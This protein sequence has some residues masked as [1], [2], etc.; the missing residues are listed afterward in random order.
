MSYIRV[1]AP[2]RELFA[3]AALRYPRLCERTATCVSIPPLLDVCV[4]VRAGES[5]TGL[6]GT[7]VLSS[8]LEDTCCPPLESTLKSGISGS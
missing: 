3:F 7:K 6:L 4:G 8:L 1:G 2:G 5:R